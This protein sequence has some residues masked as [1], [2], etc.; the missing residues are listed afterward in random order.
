MW[1]LTAILA[2]GWD[3]YFDKEE[4]KK[5]LPYPYEHYCI[6]GFVNLCGITHYKHHLSFERNYN[7]HFNPPEFFIG[8]C[9]GWRFKDIIA[10][11]PLYY[12]HAK[13]KGKNVIRL[14]GKMAR[15]RIPISEIMNRIEKGDV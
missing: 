5:E 15:V 13:N 14:Q 8:E 11:K 4:V 2:S 9:Y 1:G 10:I 3:N 12:D 7:L 6:I